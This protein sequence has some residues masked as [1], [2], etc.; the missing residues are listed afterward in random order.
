MNDEEDLKE[1]S[2]EVLET[3]EEQEFVGYEGQGL[4]LRRG[5]ALV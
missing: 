1:G 5:N 2:V 4:L 3:G